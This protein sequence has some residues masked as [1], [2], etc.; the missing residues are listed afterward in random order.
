LDWCCRSE[1]TCLQMQHR[2]WSNEVTKSDGPQGQPAHNSL[3]SPGTLLISVSH[4][5]N[6]AVCRSACGCTACGSQALCKGRRSELR[7]EGCHTRCCPPPGH[8]SHPQ[9]QV[10]SQ[11]CESCWPPVVQPLFSNLSQRLPQQLSPTILSL[12]NCDGCGKDLWPIARLGLDC[13]MAATTSAPHH[14][15]ASRT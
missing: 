9:R 1:G 15:S 10:R 14:H 3:Q 6:A 12:H 13:R 7:Q 11:S 2:G 5:E 4:K 8:P